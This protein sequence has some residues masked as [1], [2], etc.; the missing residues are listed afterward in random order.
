[1]NTLFLILIIVAA[2]ALILIV[3]IQNPKG[4]GINTEFGS[5]V[6]LGGAKR[7]NDILAKGTWGLAIGIVVLCLVLA[8]Y[9]K[10]QV[11]SEDENVTIN[12]STDAMMNSIP[13]DLNQE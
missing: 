9:Y 6:Q 2:I 5:A 12:S 11:V 13:S 7:A 8:P 1:M 10:S 3:L 4:G